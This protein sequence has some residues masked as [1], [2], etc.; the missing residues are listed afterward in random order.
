MLR[1]APRG[2]LEDDLALIESLATRPVASAHELAANLA[3]VYEAAFN[4]SLDRYDVTALARAAPALVQHDLRL[5]HAYSRQRGR[6]A[7]A[8]LHV[9]RSAAAR[10][11]ARCV[12]PA[13]PPTCWV[14]ST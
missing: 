2:R 3:Q 12:M 14:S 1:S 6:L 7:A 5:A 8:G 10:Y 11:A 9:E 4:V 13:T